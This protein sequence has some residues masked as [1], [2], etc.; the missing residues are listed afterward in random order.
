MDGFAVLRENGNDIAFGKIKW[1]ASNVDECGIAI[2][3]MPRP[4]GR[5]I[6]WLVE[7]RK[8][9]VR[10]NGHSILKL[11][12][13]KRL[14]LAYAVHSLQVDVAEMVMLLSRII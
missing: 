10:S 12:L 2:I 4:F 13:V 11:A 1:E 3:G 8:G 14:Y 7:T 9:R 6:A 5:A